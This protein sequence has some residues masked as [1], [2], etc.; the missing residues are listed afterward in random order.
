MNYQSA[1]QYLDSFINF[2]TNLHRIN[3]KD[4]SL[5]SLLEVL[6]LLGD[7]QKSLKCV[8]I[9]GSKG[10]GSL[11]SLAATVMCEAGYRVG[12]YTSP[13][14][15]DVRERIRIL[16]SRQESSRLDDL[17]SDC[18]APQD[19][20]SILQRVQNVLNQNSRW[21]LTYFEVLTASAFLY[22]Q[23]QE[24]DLVVL[25]TGLGGRLD[26]TNVVEPVVCA[27]TQ[28]D[29]EHTSILGEDIETIAVEKAGIIKR[30][31][32]A[33]VVAD[34]EPAVREVLEKKCFEKGVVPIIV[35]TGQ[36]NCGGIIQSANAN[37]AEALIN[38]LNKE[39]FRVSEENFIKGMEQNFWP[40]RMEMMEGDPPVL[41][42][43]AHT[44]KSAAILAGFLE[45]K[46]CGKNIV[47]VLGL[48]EDKDQKAIC[49]SFAGLVKSII[50][51]QSDH[52]RALFA[53]D[54]SWQTCFNGQALAQTHSIDEALVLASKQDS[55]EVVVVTGS[56][57]VVA[58]ARRYLCQKSIV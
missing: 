55:V 24:V 56:I 53:F 25:E 21:C 28:I 39:G 30:G 8:H 42:D 36:N 50:V 1:L 29:L 38:V 13:H 37:M 46:F 54:D 23:Q 57:F 11:A 6:R 51:T 15:Y 27:I 16:D 52:P 9:A 48:S 33:V 10:K 41:L 19:F 34:Q 14:F 35:G 47:L 49:K 7:P 40:G 2:E 17:F 18:I 44:K 31:C 5:E 58:Q 45:E 26:A 12:L 32:R 22:F 43:C 4:F 3:Q 20:S